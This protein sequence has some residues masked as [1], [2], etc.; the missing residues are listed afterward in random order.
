MFY[1]QFV[2]YFINLQVRY[3]LVPISYIEKRNSMYETDDYKKLNLIKSVA[4]KI[5]WNFYRNNVELKE[6]KYTIQT[7]PLQNQYLVHAQ[8][9]K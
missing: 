2:I 5:P 6:K 3:T 9:L 7:P 1:L 8:N 4:S